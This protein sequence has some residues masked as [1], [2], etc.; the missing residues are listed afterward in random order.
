MPSNEITYSEKY[1][2]DTHEYRHVTLPSVRFEKY[3]KHVTLKC[4][5]AGS[6]EKNPHQ[7]THDG[8]GVEEAWCPAES[9][10]DPLHD[11]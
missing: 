9:R 7:Q 6:P 4:C 2:D 1:T 10:L 8:D 11:P 5:D 3:L